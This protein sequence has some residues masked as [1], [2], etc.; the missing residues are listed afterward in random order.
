MSLFYFINLNLIALLLINLTDP[1]SSTIFLKA[2][3]CCFC[4]YAWLYNCFYATLQL[5]TLLVVVL[6]SL[7]N[8]DIIRRFRSLPQARIKLIFKTLVVQIF[9]ELSFLNA[10]HIYYKL[11][12]PSFNRRSR[13]S[14]ILLLCLMKHSQARSFSPSLESQIP[15]VFWI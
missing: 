8:C 9:S 11:L 4:F 10:L 2:D 14:T 7:M 15:S 3:I 12:R 6:D 1:A 5:E 13:C